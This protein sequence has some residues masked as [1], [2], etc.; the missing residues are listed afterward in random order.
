MARRSSIAI[1]I[2]WTL[3]VSA[4][5]GEDH[6]LAGKYNYVGSADKATLELSKDGKY[7]FCIPSGPCEVNKYDVESWS[8]PADR[9]F[10]S[11]KAMIQFTA[12]GWV[13]VIYDEGYCPCFQFQD[14]DSGVQFEK[15]GESPRV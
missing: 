10:F 6:T 8:K 14:P 13:N 9:I 3:C 5:K 2:V 15:T 12:G 7:K 1:A 4:C 11:G